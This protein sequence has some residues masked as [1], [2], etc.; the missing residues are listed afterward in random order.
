MINPNEQEHQ[1]LVKIIRNM[2]G[3]LEKGK[4]GEKEFIS[5]YEQL[6]K[7]GRDVLKKEWEVVKKA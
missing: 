5:S 4:D 6:L 1:A 7:E 3:A 2:V